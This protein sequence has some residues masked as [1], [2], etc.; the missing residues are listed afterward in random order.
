MSPN[1]SNV[2]K[3]TTVLNRFLSFFFL[4]FF[5]LFFFLEKTRF[6]N[7]SEEEGRKNTRRP[8]V[9]AF[10]RV[11]LIKH[12]NMIQL[13]TNIHIHVCTHAATSEDA[14]SQQSCFLILP[15]VSFS[16]FFFLYET[17]K[18]AC[19]GLCTQ[20]WNLQKG[21]ALRHL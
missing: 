2:Q 13:H 10:I 12:T 17:V 19:K 14:L 21:R 9:T 4:F 15:S 7:R 11:V 1:Q 16:L 8:E 18:L 20:E 3:L 5:I 6:Y